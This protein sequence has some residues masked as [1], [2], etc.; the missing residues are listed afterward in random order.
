MIRIAHDE[1]QLLRDFFAG[2][3]RTIWEAGGVPSGM[4]SVS[5]ATGVPMHGGPPSDRTPEISRASRRDIVSLDRV[6]TWLKRCNVAQRAVLRAAFGPE[7]RGSQ[8]ASYGEYP[9]A[10][11]AS[12]AV[13]AEHR[14]SRT[15]DGL[16]EWLLKRAHVARDIEGPDGDEAQATVAR[17]RNLV[18]D[19]VADALK[20]CGIR[21][22]RPRGTPLSLKD[23]A[24]ATGQA[25]KTVLRQLRAAGMEPE[26]RG[27]SHAVHVDREQL[28]TVD[29]EMARV[30]D[31]AG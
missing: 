25:P 1:E 12:L 14:A 3:L 10:L 5:F 31:A 22:E 30:V 9:G 17:I 28:R 27:S 6:E 16:P 20:A 13:A 23:I 15:T 29:P 8:F 19:A 4:G 26:P 11:F 21:V 7:S 2:H 18:E 24:S